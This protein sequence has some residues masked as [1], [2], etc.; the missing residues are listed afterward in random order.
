MSSTES[1]PV[2]T[3]EGGEDALDADQA[4]P[5]PIPKDTQ[6][7]MLKNRRRRDILRYLRENGGESTLSDLAEFIAAKEN[8]VERR[9]LSS[10]E[11]K[12]VYIGLYQCHLPKMNDAR[13]VDFDK[14]SGGVTLRPEADQLFAYIDD[15]APDDSEEGDEADAGGVLSQWLGD[16]RMRLGLSWSL[17]LVA[18]LSTLG[19]PNLPP[20]RLLGVVA[21]VTFAVVET[22][23]LLPNR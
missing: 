23:D 9:L 2:S 21:I 8:G 22:A 18:I 17:C 7:G 5:E 19:I 1:S 20:V 13:V 14:R 16:R 6:F 10:D 3:K 15:D 12:R 11:R 4:E